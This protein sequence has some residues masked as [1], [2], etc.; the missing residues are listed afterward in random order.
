MTHDIK[1]LLQGMKTLAAAGENTTDA[2]AFHELF[3]KQ[4]PNVNERLETTLRKLTEPNQQRRDKDVKI[5]QWWEDLQQRCKGRNMTLTAEID[6]DKSVPDE[7]F[8]TVSENLLD[9]ARAKRLNQR[10]ID[11]EVCLVSKPDL[12]SF[13]VMDTGHPVPANKA[14][15]LLSEPVKSEQ[16]LGVGLYQSA[17]L[18]K[19]QGYSLILESN[20]EGN[21]RFTLTNEQ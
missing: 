8:N 16:G 6:L 20:E 2:K 9:N 10:D 18:A 17:A 13:S 1:N 12:L 11:I 7:M 5:S 3:I 14:D 19:H 15:Y 21:V 4:I